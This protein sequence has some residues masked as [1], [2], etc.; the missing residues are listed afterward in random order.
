MEKVLLGHEGVQCLITSKVL[1]GRIDVRVGVGV[2][3]T[4]A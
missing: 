4:A 2:G 1:G 3:V